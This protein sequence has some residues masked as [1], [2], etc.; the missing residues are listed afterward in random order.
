MP[1]TLEFDRLHAALSGAG[2]ADL[3]I[4]A[5]T[6]G[7]A[8]PTRLACE[9]A[10]FQV[11]SD[12]GAFYAK[13]LYDDMRPVVDFAQSVEATR[14][15]AATGVTP[16]VQ[17]ADAAN[18]VLLLEQL[19]PEDWHW[20]HLDRL[21][22]EA[23]LAALWRLKLKV[24]E[25]PAPAFARSPWADIERLR[26]L[27]RAQ[28]VALPD[29]QAWIDDCVDLAWAALQRQPIER[30]PLHGDG[31]AGN[32]MVNAAG[33]LRLL[34]FDRGG[35]FDPWYDVAVTLNELYPFESQWRAG[36]ARWSGA[37]SDADYA[38]CRLYGLLDDWYWTLWGFWAGVASTRPLEFS[39]VGQWTLLRCRTTIQE[40]RFESW[41]RQVGG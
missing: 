5:G 21:Q 15:A 31:L 4:T 35:C 14:C 17:L 26:T 16:A 13:V 18:G 23:S 19:A 34:D 9:W 36:I 6:P 10:G 39:K 33:E 3:Q 41:L 22:P 38:R 32:V 37:A 30:R 20:A 24:Q 40:P 8:S 2:L 27:C 25:G 11:Q 12:Q 1:S 28:A 7:V 29:D